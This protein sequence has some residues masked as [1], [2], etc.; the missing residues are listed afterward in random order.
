MYDAV[1]KGGFN[2]TNSKYKDHLN[3]LS[4]IVG[5]RARQRS[6]VSSLQ[7]NHGKGQT[8]FLYSL[9][10]TAPPV[11]RAKKPWAKTSMR[12]MADEA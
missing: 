1:P 10:A 3:R 2:K 11:G 7:K 5:G 4:P 12:V 9:E 8:V 6:L